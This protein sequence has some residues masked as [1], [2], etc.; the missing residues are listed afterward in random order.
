MADFHDNIGEFKFLQIFVTTTVHESQRWYELLYTYLRVSIYL[1]D[2]L[3]NTQSLESVM[4]STTWML[5]EGDVT[6]VISRP[7]VFETKIGPYLS[8]KVVY[9]IGFPARCS[10]SHCVAEEGVWIL[11]YVESRTNPW[12]PVMYER[13]LAWGSSARQEE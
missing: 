4:E 1:A 3:E 2:Q 11:S 13:C 10:Y 8:L 9:K 12:N 7:K 6:N 5:T